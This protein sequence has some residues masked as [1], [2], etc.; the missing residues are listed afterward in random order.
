MPATDGGLDPAGERDAAGGD[1]ARGRRARAQDLPEAGEA[2]GLKAAIVAGQRGRHR[3]RRLSARAARSARTSGYGWLSEETEDDPARRRPSVLWIVDPIDGTRAYLAGA[4]RLGDLGGAGAI[5]GRPVVAAVFAPVTDEM[6]L[7]GAGARRDPQRRADR[8]ERRRSARR[9]EGRGPKTPGATR[10]PPSCRAH[11][12][13]AAH[14]LARAA[15]R[16]RRAGRA[17]RRVC[18]RQQPRLG[19]CGRRPFGARSRRAR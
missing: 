17:R 11:R 9:R 16:P 3:G 15:P 12:R 1:R 14:R 6:F 2:A 4:A 7:A 13:R 5:G 18:L 19:P 10:S 8:G